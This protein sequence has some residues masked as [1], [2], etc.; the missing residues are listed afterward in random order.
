MAD[1][2]EVLTERKIL[3]VPT[4][5]KSLVEGLI[6]AARDPLTVRQIRAIY[7]EQSGDR[8]RRLE[9][10]EIQTIIAGLN[11]EYR[12]ADRP[13]RIITIAGGYQFATLKE[14]AEW[15]GLLFHEQSR[16]KLSQSSLETLAIVA[17]KQPISKPEVESI[18]GVNCDYVMKALLEKDLVT[19]VGRAETVGRPLL[20][21]TTREFLRHFGLGEITDLPRPREIEE[22]LGESE[23]ETARRMMEAQEGAEQM[24]KEEEFKSRLPHIPKKSPELDD[25]VKIVPKGRP[26]RIAVKQRE[27]SRPE[28]PAAAVPESLPDQPAI[29]GPGDQA[30]EAPPTA[31]PPPL[32]APVADQMDGEGDDAAQPEVSP[33]PVRDGLQDMRDEQQTI[34][35]EPVQPGASPL[36]IQEESSDV[37][38]GSSLDHL[39]PI[40]EPEH[41]QPQTS[42][43]AGWKQK[44]QTF[45]RKLFG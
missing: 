4:T 39:P 43:W 33:A 31:V 35:P 29:E 14:Y 20:Y 44:I 8:D 19:I 11:E 28:E 38:S 16:R 42:A 15:L 7:E 40:Q 36:A 1:Q 22:I 26:R 41:S 17:Y 9:Q 21:G 45:I 37:V 30:D 27:E 34:P 13:Y 6:F 32:G 18:R 10:E 25:D 23:F 3:K 24:K 5:L 2:Q 12:S